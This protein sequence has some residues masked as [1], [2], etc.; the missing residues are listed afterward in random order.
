MRRDRAPALALVLRYP[1]APGGRADREALAGIVN[2]ETVPVDE[3]VG[4]LL[5][6]AVAQDGERFAA[7]ARACYHQLRLERHAPL[8]L[9]RG[10]EPRRI[11]IARMH[12]D[13]E[14]ELRRRDGGDLL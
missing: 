10:H 6:Q 4:V 7:I 9:V 8:V 2:R 14:T 5:R 12:R 1:Q 3:V 13:S 11:G